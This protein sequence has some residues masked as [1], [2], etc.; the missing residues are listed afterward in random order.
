MGSCSRRDGWPVRFGTFLRF[1]YVY[2]IYIWVGWG[3]VWW[4]INVLTTTSLIYTT[5]STHV[6]PTGTT[7]MMQ[8]DAT[9]TVRWGG[10]GWGGISTSS[11]PRPWYI[12]RC[13]RMFHQLGRPWWCNMMLSWQYVGV[14]WGEWDINVLTTYVLD[15]YYVVNACSTNWDDLDDATWCYIDKWAWLWCRWIIRQNSSQ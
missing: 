1:I 13:Q 15:I 8:H 5:L 2:I 4:D 14:G 7:L 9:L 6:P 12:L 3:G 11:R 10:V